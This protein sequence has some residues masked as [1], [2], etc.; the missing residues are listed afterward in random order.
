MNSIDSGNF[1]L[2]SF[3]KVIH[4]FPLNKPKNSLT[5][6]K[7]FGRDDLSQS[8]RIQL[9][10]RLENWITELTESLSHINA[11]KDR[12]KKLWINTE[13]GDLVFGGKSKGLKDVDILFELDG[14][15]YYLEA[16]SNLE[17][18]TEKSITTIAKVNKIVDA[19]KR[20]PKF[21][22]KKVVGKVLTFFWDDTKVGGLKVP[23]SSNME[24]N[25]EN[26]MF[27]KELSELLG[28]EINKE[29]YEKTCL[30]IG[31]SL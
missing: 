14:I 27:F 25:S 5:I 18:D 8:H 11:I 22:N 16:K 17:L 9:G 10:D 6:A 31:T 7:F 13:S 19:L 26:V 12:S 20:N 15:I 2:Q 24:N 29:T 23:Y 28:F 30:K 4:E 1:L 3:Q 21:S